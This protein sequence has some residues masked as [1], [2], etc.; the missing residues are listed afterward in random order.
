MELDSEIGVG[1][2]YDHWYWDSD[3]SEDIPEPNTLEVPLYQSRNSLHT[4]E[5]EA[6]WVGSYIYNDNIEETSWIQL[7]HD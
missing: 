7:G 5:E 2:I 3:T 1:E 6:F 4:F